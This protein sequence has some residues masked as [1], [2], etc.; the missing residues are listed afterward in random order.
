MDLTKPSRKVSLFSVTSLF[1]F[2]SRPGHLCLP[3][4]FKVRDKSG[5]R[6]CPYVT[7]LA[8]PPETSPLCA[9]LLLAFRGP[10]RNNQCNTPYTS[11]QANPDTPPQAF[12]SYDSGC[13]Q[14]PSSMTL[15]W[16]FYHSQPRNTSKRFVLLAPSGPILTVLMALCPQLFWF[17]LH[18]GA[19][20]CG[21]PVSFLSKLKH[22]TEC[23]TQ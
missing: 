7:L 8:N 3:S 2:F 21:S 18:T 6:S 12:L 22:R 17:L 13:A 20:A 16:L 19:K 5:W 9:F 23:V 1:L 11:P 10:L 14:C 4:F 15:L